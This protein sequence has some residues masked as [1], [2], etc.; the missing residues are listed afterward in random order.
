MVNSADSTRGNI[1]LTGLP[2]TKCFT[3]WQDFLAALPEFLG[4]EIPVSSITNVVV[5][6]VEP[7]SSQTNSIWFRLNNAGGF[8]GIYVFS[9]GIWNDIYPVNVDSPVVTNQIFWFFG[10]SAQPPPG[11]TNTND[12]TGL[13]AAVKAALA[14][15]WNFEGG[16]FN[17]YSAVYIGF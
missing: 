3:S 13:T 15:Q 5:S 6:N 7:S 16:I 2:D 14:A 11:W 10:D 8:I 4:V 9:A 17:Y 1:V 12:Y